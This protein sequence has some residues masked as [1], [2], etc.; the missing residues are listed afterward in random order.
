MS[1]T[2]IHERNKVEYHALSTD[3]TSGSIQGATW[4]GAKVTLTDTGQK[5]FVA[6]DF[7]LLPYGGGATGY[8]TATETIITAGSVS[9]SLVAANASR[10]YLF[11]QNQS[12]TESVYLSTSTSATTS[13]V[14]LSAGSNKELYGYSLYRGALKVITS[15]STTATLAIVEGT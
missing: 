7:E 9:G 10:K 13:N 11:I 4:V 3:V 15:G 6:T 1:L 12:G 5:Y 14:S 2:V 8:T